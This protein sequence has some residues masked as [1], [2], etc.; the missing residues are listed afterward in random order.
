MSRFRGCCCPEIQVSARWERVR[1]AQKSRSAPENWR[2]AMKVSCIARS[3]QIITK[4]VLP[5]GSF[6]NVSDVSVR[7]QIGDECQPSFARHRTIGLP[8][9]P[10]ILYTRD[11]RECKHSSA[12]TLRPRFG[13]IEQLPP[14][15]IGALQRSERFHHCQ[16]CRHDPRT[17]RML[18]GSERSSSAIPAATQPLPRPQKKGASG[19]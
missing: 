13:M 7:V 5:A 12:R 16:V 14:H 10:S 2:L 8:I 19:A 17:L 18:G 9:E 4:V 6:A 3:L 11:H 1:S 15:T